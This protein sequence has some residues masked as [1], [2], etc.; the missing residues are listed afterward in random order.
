[1]KFCFAPAGVMDIRAFAVR[2]MDVLTLKFIFPRFGG[3]A[4]GF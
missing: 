2:V 3:P 4:G 1:M